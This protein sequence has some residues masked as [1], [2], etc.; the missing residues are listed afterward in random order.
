MADN[1]GARNHWTTRNTVFA[2]WNLLHSARRLVDGG[3][4]PA[5]G[6]KTSNRDLSDP[7]HPNPEYR[8]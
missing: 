6:S 7:D 4:V 3:G 1:Q 2:A 8:A 5:C